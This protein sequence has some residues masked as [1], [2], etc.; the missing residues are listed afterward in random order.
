MSGGHTYATLV[1]T[2]RLFTTLMSNDFSAAERRRFIR[3]LQLLDTDERHPSLRVHQ[4]RGDQAGIWSAS[5]S[6]ELRITFE[7][8][9]DGKKR[10]LLCSWHYQR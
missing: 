4:L 1:F 10:M 2:D 5:A 6:D 7:R 3:A 8:L 9:P